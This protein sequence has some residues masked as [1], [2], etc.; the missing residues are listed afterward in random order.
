MIAY[1]AGPTLKSS[2]LATLKLHYRIQTITMSAAVR[3]YRAGN[4]AGMGYAPYTDEAGDDTV[5]AAVEAAQ[6]VDGWEV[7]LRRKTTEDVVVLRN[8]DGELMAIGDAHGA[9]A[10]DITSEVCS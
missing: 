6:R 3:A 7:V 4:N 5:E 2:I 9:W 10:V 1:H 8:A